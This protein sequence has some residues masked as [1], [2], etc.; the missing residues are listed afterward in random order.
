M[1]L[2][3]PA[4][5]DTVMNTLLLCLLQ[6]LSIVYTKSSFEIWAKSLYR[7]FDYKLIWSHKLT[8]YR[9]LMRIRITHAL[10]VNGG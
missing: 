4:Y 3:L 1:S 6:F 10:S 2:G 7:I 9:R 5:Q 8:D